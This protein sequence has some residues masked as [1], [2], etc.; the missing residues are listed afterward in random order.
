MTLAVDDGLFGVEGV[1]NERKSDI[2][3]DVFNAACGV[4]LNDD[5][6]DIAAPTDISSVKGRVLSRCPA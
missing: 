3:Y 1:E 2:I 6:T 5:I 4:A